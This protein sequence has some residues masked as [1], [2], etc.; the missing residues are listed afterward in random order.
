[1][2]R[3]RAGIAEARALVVQ[4][5]QEANKRQEEARREIE[6]IRG[7]VEAERAKAVQEREAVQAER[8]QFKVERD[9]LAA[10][11]VKFG[12][13][14]SALEREMRGVRDMAVELEA[15]AAEVAELKRQSEKDMIEAAQVA[16]ASRKAAHEA[17]QDKARCNEA[18]RLARA[19]KV[20]L[21]K[22]KA[23]LGAEKEAIRSL[24]QQAARS[25]EAA[26]LIEQRLTGQLKQ[27][28]STH[29]A[30]RELDPQNPSY[31]NVPR[32][33]VSEN[34]PLS[35]PMA[36]DLKKSRVTAEDAAGLGVDDL[37]WCSDEARKGKAYLQSQLRFL[38]ELSA[39]ETVADFDASADRENVMFMHEYTFGAAVP[40]SLLGDSVMHH[41]AGEATMKSFATNTTAGGR[42]G[43]RPVSM[44]ESTIGSVAPNV[45]LSSI[46]SEGAR[47]SEE[48]VE[49][50]EAG[51]DGV[52]EQVSGDANSE[53][54]GAGVA[55]HATPDGST[56]VSL[57]HRNRRH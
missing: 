48:G 9:Q 16:E 45:G 26:R 12:E 30:L 52:G 37:A 50:R 57:P 22:E 21:D 53:P 36:F 18:E 42:A 7:V 6:E 17:A 25:A 19:S 41:H 43:Y 13:G 32:G 4:Q 8:A 24:K 33:E 46:R 34:D 5:Q 11:R 38:M 29:S 27:H 54:Q 56:M 49:V 35:D 10:D 2:Q 20:M 39:G 47:E 55:G 1:L 14:K 44:L 23:D 3:E 51:Q 28:N 31:S 15:K 40:E